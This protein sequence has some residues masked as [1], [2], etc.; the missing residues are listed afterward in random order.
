MKGR[1]DKGSVMV[2]TLILTLIVLVAG[3]GLVEY[4]SKGSRSTGTIKAKEISFNVAKM[5][6]K[7]TSEVLPKVSDLEE[8]KC[9]D[10]QTR[11]AV[12][13]DSY[14]RPTITIGGKAYEFE[15][16]VE[17][18][19]GATV[20]VLVTG[21]GPKE[22]ESQ[23]RVV[24]TLG[25]FYPFWV[26]ETFTINDFQNNR[27]WTDAVLAASELSPD[28]LEGELVSAGFSVVSPPPA[29]IPSVSDLDLEEALNSFECD[30]GGAGYEEVEL[31]ESSDFDDVNGDGVVVVCAEEIK[32]EREECGHGGHGHG[33]GGKGHHEGSHHA[34]TPSLISLNK[35]LV[36][37]AKEEIEIEDVTLKFSSL[38]EANFV[39]VVT[40]REEEEGEEEEGEIKVE[41]ASIVIGSSVSKG[42]N[43]LLVAP[44]V[45]LEAEDDDHCGHGGKHGGKHGGCGH[46]GGCGSGSTVIKVQG[47][48]SDDTSHIIVAASKRFWFGGKIDITGNKKE[49]L[50]LLWADEGISVKTD[51][52]DH[53]GH[54]GKH[55][56]KHGGCGHG[57]GCGSGKAGG[58]I[59]VTG[60][61]SEK[62]IL[63]SVLSS[64]GGAAF[65]SWKFTGSTK[66]AGVT[67]EDIYE[68]C[69]DMEDLVEDE[70]VREVFQE[71]FCN[72]KEQ[73]AEKAS[74]EVKGMG[75][76]Y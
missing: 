45:K 9:I 65:S 51:E 8:G 59:E 64:E 31:N 41:D 10:F 55:G 38:E 20:S 5:G 70:N 57:G 7:L 69:S 73:L 76:V 26:K 68:R 35:S 47:G 75:V 25:T 58:V 37:I 36:L 62:G 14:T 12:D 30:V 18:V 32:I 33:C 44:E 28:S 71:V 48:A 1:K 15:A 54:G 16:K 13:C 17:R 46:G 4:S 11:K 22:V 21:Y 66:R 2:A 74:S 49:T 61:S 24:E 42:Y 34:E 40:G 56:G 23:V 3:L 60:T 53:C 19:S 27:E 52:D 29:G 72:L 63:F 39:A 50:I 67:Y 6:A 43:I